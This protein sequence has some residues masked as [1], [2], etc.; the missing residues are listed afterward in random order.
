[1]RLH[2]ACYM[3]GIR[4][5][6]TLLTNG[7]APSASSTRRTLFLC[8]PRRVSVTITL[9]EKYTF[10]NRAPGFHVLVRRF[11]FVRPLLCT[12]ALSNR[13]SR[14]GQHFRSM[15]HRRFRGRPLES[16]LLGPLWAI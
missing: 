2:S 11:F 14:P 8:C 16:Q 13:D 7:L 12:F 6:P 15:C 4:P 5:S 10:R 1:M 9:P 3:S